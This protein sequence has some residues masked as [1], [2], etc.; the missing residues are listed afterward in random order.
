MLAV[1]GW[2]AWLAEANPSA[3]PM[4]AW[5]LAVVVL[6]TSTVLNGYHFVF[7]LYTP[8]SLAAAPSLMRVWD[9]ARTRRWGLAGVVALAVVLVQAPLLLTRK[10]LAEVETHRIHPTSARVLDLLAGLPPGNVLAPADLGN[11]VPAYGPHRVYVGHWFLTPQYAQRANEALAAATGRMGAAELVALVDG[12]RLRYL[13]VATQA[14]PALMSTLGARVERT[15][16]LGELT[17]LVLAGG[18]P[19]EAR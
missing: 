11:F 10:C 16:E 8:V 19:L 2:R 17:V 18:T 5:T 4:A 12:Q 1:R 3:L 13:V 15:V 6:H 14:A 9:G 7:H